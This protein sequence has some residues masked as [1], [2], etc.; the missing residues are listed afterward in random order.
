MRSNSIEEFD[1][2]G[3]A[4]TT[5]L[6]SVSDIEEDLRVVV[7]IPDE[8]RIPLSEIGTKR[9]K[10]SP[11]T[12]QDHIRGILGEFAVAKHLGVPDK[13]DTEIY[14]DGDEGYDL[15]FNNKTI[16]VKTLGPQWNRPRLIVPVYQG[17]QADYYVLVQEISST[18]YEI[19]GYAPAAVVADSKV[20]QIPGARIGTRGYTV[21]Q[22]KL[23]PIPK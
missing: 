15:Q 10:D 5:P 23:T 9:A 1:T 4:A 20:E 7:N 12:I 6:I 18:T 14:D 19:I 16:D 17:I 13:V 11:G 22:Y 21:E 8:K 3:N 2:T